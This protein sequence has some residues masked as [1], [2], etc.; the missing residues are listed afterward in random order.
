M[1]T[2]NEDLKEYW[3]EFYTKKDLQ[4]GIRLIGE[5]AGG[6]MLFGVL[7]TALTVWIPGLGIP[8]SGFVASRVMMIAYKAYGNMDAEQRKQVRA[9]VRWVKGG[10]NL[11][12]G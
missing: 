2:L 7:A 8:V 12:D 4:A 1:A 10:I 9:V 11:I 5:V 3:D 6:I